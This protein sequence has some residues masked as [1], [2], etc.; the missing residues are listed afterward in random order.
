MVSGVGTTPP[1]LGRDQRKVE[2]V[3][4]IKG[5]P[6]TSGAM[7]KDGKCGM[8]QEWAYAPIESPFLGSTITASFL[9]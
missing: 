6:T 9:R 4:S 3:R 8:A 7:K 2:A 5:D 1:I